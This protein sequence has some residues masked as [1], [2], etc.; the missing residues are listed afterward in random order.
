MSGRALPTRQL[1]LDLPPAAPFLREDFLAVPAN[2]AALALVEAYPDWPGPVVALVGPAGSGKT[3][4]AAIFARMTQAH[5]LKARDLDRLNVPDALAAGVLVL[6]DLEPGG[7]DE[8]ALFH[9]LNLAREQGAHVL[10]TGRVPPASLPLVTADLV[11]RLKAIPMVEIACADDGLLAA[12]LV[13]LFADRQIPVDEPSV[14]YLLRRM[15]RSV[16]GAQMLVAA[17]D[18]AALAARRPVTR[19]LIAEVLRAADAQA[20]D[21]DPA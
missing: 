4:L 13:K 8:A 1:S 16:E 10:L 2:A 5:V 6:E 20:E 11:S 14:Q 3:H 12:V 21:E 18:R 9:V 17:I 19:A 7:V 15:P